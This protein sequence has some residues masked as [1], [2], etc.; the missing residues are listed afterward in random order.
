LQL[1]LAVTSR[2]SSVCY[3]SDMVRSC[4]KEHLERRLEA[5]GL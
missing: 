5:G 1:G 2:S 3:R 4:G